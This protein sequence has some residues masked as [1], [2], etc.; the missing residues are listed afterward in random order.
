MRLFKIISLVTLPAL[1]LLHMPQTANAAL[2]A[3]EGFEDNT[4]GQVL[5]GNGNGGT[6]WTNDWN[7]L[8]ARAAEVTV[9]S[10]TM[11]YAAGEIAIDGGSRM[12]RYIASENSIQAI[13]GR[14]FPAQTGTIYMSFLVQASANDN[15]AARND[16]Y[17]FG[18]TDS[19]YTG[20][21][22]PDINPLVSGMDRNGTI[23]LRSGTSTSIDSTISTGVGNTFFL[24][25]RAEKTGLS[26]TYNDLTLY[27]NPDSATEGLNTSITTATDS[28]LD[29][30]GNGAVAIRKAFLENGDTYLLDEIRV[31]TTFADVITVVPEPSTM[32]L[33][34]LGG[35]FALRRR[36]PK[37]RS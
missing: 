28:T 22:A 26:S 17:Q 21:G 19:T 14:N 1:L 2:I 11:S 35:L 29:L 16:L 23:Q 3:Y 27:I 18:F 30:S 9:Q 8:N 7:I 6:G 10:S 36:K 12:L 37:F 15:P 33:L 5:D 24:V 31:G 4:V 25:L 34:G 32:V 13:G 20:G